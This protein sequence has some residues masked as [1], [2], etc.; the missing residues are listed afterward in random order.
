MEHKG[1]NLNDNIDYIFDINLR[2]HAY[3]QEKGI[4]DL[5]FVPLCI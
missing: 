5:N 4:F 2:Y 3:R 1:N